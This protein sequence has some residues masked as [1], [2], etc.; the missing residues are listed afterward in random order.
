[1][2]FVIPMQSDSFWD[3]NEGEGMSLGSIEKNAQGSGSS[4]AEV[5]LFLPLCVGLWFVLN[6]HPGGLGSN[7]E[8]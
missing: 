7:N 2:C 3:T 8:K 4:F 6:N 1:M 5:S